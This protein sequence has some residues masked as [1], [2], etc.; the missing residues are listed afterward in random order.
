MISPRVAPG[1]IE[2]KVIDEHTT[3]SNTGTASLGNYWLKRV[4]HFITNQNEKRQS[5][6]GKSLQREELSQEQ[7]QQV[8]GPPQPVEQQQRQPRQQSQQLD[9]LLT[10]T[11]GQ[12]ATVLGDVAL[13]VQW[14]PQ[15]HV[16]C[17][18]EHS[19]ESGMDVDNTSR[20]LSILRA[21]SECDVDSSGN[22]VSSPVPSVLF[23]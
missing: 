23:R 13:R 6:E 11:H 5:Q 20:F 9:K 14:S 17:H 10:Q 8:H 4:R 18:D 7:L 3:R 12:R 15:V 16:K 19:T 21:C 1:S 22:S 2:P